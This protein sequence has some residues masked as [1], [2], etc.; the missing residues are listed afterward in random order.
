MEG[1]FFAFNFQARQ[2]MS[3]LGN[4]CDFEMKNLHFFVPKGPPLK[5]SQN[6]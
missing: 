2:K 5:I 1:K 6:E 3:T 4:Y